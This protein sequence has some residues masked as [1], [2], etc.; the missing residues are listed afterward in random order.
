MI[1]DRQMVMRVTALERIV[2]RL[3]TKPES[4]HFIADYEDW[5]AK[6]AER[7]AGNYPGIDWDYW[8]TLALYD[9]ASAY[10]GRTNFAFW[11]RA[12]LRFHEG[13]AVEQYQGQQRVWMHWF[14]HGPNPKVID[15]D[16]DR[17]RANRA[18]AKSIQD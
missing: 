7:R 8:Y 14:K 12:R 9:A 15:K 5:V 3:K 1:C 17:K 10:D 18:Q 4:W 6:L 11:F 2:E 13:H 16:R